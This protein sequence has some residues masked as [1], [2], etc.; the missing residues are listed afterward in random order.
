MVVDRCN[1]EVGRDEED[2]SEDAS[3]AKDM[4]EETDG[5]EVLTLSAVAFG[6]ATC[7]AIVRKT[8]GTSYTL[9]L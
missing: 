5:K 6:T 9:P 7:N 8:P 1:K 4:D 3:V 2:D